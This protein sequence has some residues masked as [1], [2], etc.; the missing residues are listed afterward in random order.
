MSTIASS[1]TYREDLEFVHKSVIEAVSVD[2][3]GNKLFNSEKFTDMCELVFDDNGN[4]KDVAMKLKRRVNDRIV[5]E[6]VLTS[7]YSVQELSEMIN[8]SVR[9][10]DYSLFSDEKDISLNDRYSEENMT[11]V[12]SKK[13]SS[14]AKKKELNFKL[15]KKEVTVKY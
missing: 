12:K 2:S 15:G 8:E 3:N 7:N 5:E 1:A 6:K 13:D 11:E 10:G 9:L 4:L 14:F